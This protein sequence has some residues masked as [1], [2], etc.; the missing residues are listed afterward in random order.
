MREFSKISPTVWRSRKFKSLPDMEAKFVYFYI[1]TSPHN[2]SAG[3]YDLHPMYAGAD[4]GITD[5][6][7]RYCIDTLSK[8]N[9][10]EFDNDENT[11]MIIN[12]ENY[13][14]PMNPKHALGLLYQLNQASSKRLKLIVFSKFLEIFKAKGFD[15]NQALANAIDTLS[16]EYGYCIPTYTE[17]ETEIETENRPDLDKT[18]TDTSAKIET[19]PN[20]SLAIAKGHG[21]LPSPTEGAL[22]SRLL[23]TP[24]MK[25]NH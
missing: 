15:A 18:F 16:I 6:Q 17:T 5:I 11:V 20:G 3:C 4:L 24:L 10:I 12:W 7:F 13:N 9:L 22:K 19:P 25:R 1:L 23:Q 8:A 14:E 21:G 2:N